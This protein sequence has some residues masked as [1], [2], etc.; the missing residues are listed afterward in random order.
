MYCMCTACA[1]PVHVHGMCTARALHVCAR[2]RAR[3]LLVAKPG[4][5]Q[6]PPHE[7]ALRCGQ[8]AAQQGP[9]SGESEGG[10]SRL[11]VHVER[12]VGWL[13]SGLGLGLGSGLGLGLGSG[14]GLG[15]GLGS[16]L[17]LGLE[18]GLGLGLRSGLGVEVGVSSR[19]LRADMARV[20]L[21]QD[22]LARSKSDAAT[23]GW[24]A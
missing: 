21:G 12:L 5:E 15:L 9:V 4:L 1:R 8:G 24:A 10:V 17:G 2:A 18:L 11:E 19:M 22:A 6:L 23:A 3:L 14:L 20:R 13:G 16:G 7:G